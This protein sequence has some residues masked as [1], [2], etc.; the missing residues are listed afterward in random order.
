MPDW[1]IDGIAREVIADVIDQMGE[2]VYDTVAEEFEDVGD[3]ILHDVCFPLETNRGFTQ[4]EE[5]RT[6]CEKF[7]KQIDDSVFNAVNAG[8]ASIQK[9]LGVE[10][11]DFAGM[12]FSGPHSS[13][14]MYQEYRIYM[15]AQ[16]RSQAGEPE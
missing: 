4:R 16:M 2:T 13:F 7:C 9:D 15:I 14:D 3:D 6:A 12:H 5:V 8:I 11:G 10:H 1:N